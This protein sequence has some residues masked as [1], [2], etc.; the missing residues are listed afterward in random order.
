MN[1]IHPWSRRPCSRHSGIPFITLRAKSCSSRLD[2]LSRPK[3]KRERLV[4]QGYL[5]F[6]LKKNIFHNSFL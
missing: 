4:R 1:S 6:N 2:D 3:I 5:I